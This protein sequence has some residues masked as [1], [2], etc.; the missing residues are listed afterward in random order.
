MAGIRA[1]WAHGEERKFGSAL[2]DWHASW[3]I[4]EGLWAS[5]LRANFLSNFNA[6][7]ALR[8][9]RQDVPIRSWGMS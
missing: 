8:I 9:T 6:V 2:Q 3:S 1:C 4:K 7:S 5:Q